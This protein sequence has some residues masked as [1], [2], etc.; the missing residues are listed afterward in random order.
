MQPECIALIILAICILLFL[1][2]WINSAATAVLGCM[3][4]VLTGISTFEEAFSGFSNSIVILVF[5]MLVVGDALFETGVGKVI[6]DQVLRLSRNS[7]RRFLLIAGL[8]SAVLS[9]FLSNVTVI[10]L[11]LAIINSIIKSS[12]GIDIKNLCLATAL[13]AIFG[14]NCT[15]VGST[16]QL[17]VQAI[18]SQ[19][20]GMEYRLFDYMYAGI[21]LTLFYL[22]FI[23][24][25][26]YPLGKKIWG[27]RK[28]LAE[29]DRV[30][31][32]DITRTQKTN[33]GSKG[34]RPRMAFIFSLMILLF[35]TELVDTAMAAAIAAML[36]VI[37]QC[38]SAESIFR[39]MNW[40]VIIWLA[41]CLGIAKGLVSSGCGKLL[42][43]GF[44][45]L[46]GEDVHPMVFLAA[47]VFLTILI[48]NFINN[49]TAVLIVL[50]PVLAVCTKLGFNPM[51]FGIAVCYS[52]NLV[53]LTPLA[54]AQIGLTMVAGYRFS[55]YVKYGA[56]LE[57]VVF[58]GIMIFVPLAFP[59]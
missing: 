32:D 35:V 26:G 12:K 23:L 44:I 18:M 7:E 39:H 28:E 48:S 29:N 22:V 16:P 6:G 36:C 53:F 34:K 21:P 50:P 14:G 19:T 31:L 4:F 13:G 42:A 55:D 57:L 1:T 27:T 49:S 9:A 10:T 51:T 8:E 47:A 15:L 24:L 11:N 38:T 25:I 17:T 56:I 20:L 59:L 46:F 45:S 41:G 3:L 54:S 30:Y 58:A 5:S 2:N 33:V 52:A 37:M 43:A 40:K